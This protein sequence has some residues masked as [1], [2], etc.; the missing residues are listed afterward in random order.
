MEDMYFIKENIPSLKNSK[1][2]TKQGV[3]SSPTV[4]KFLRKYGIKHYSSGKKVVEV[5]KTIPMTFPVEELKDLFK[6]SKWPIEIGFHFVRNSRH[7]FDFVNAV[8]IILDL[9][10]AFDVIPDDS[11]DFVIPRAFK[12]ND[13]FYTYNK[14]NPGVYVK[15]IRE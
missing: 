2:S 4:Q 15:I 13:K 8:Q 9:F 11:M 7:R 1:I 10:T 5:Y 6:D 3:F 12:I 14:E